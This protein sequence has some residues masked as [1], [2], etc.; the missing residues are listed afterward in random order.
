M[1]TRTVKLTKKLDSLN[2]EK[3]ESGRFENASEVIR[4]TRRTVEPGTTE[5]EVKF[6]TLRAAIDDGDDGGV[7]FGNPFARVREELKLAKT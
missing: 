1:P 6:A 5:Y 4:V 2:V 7:A 3:V